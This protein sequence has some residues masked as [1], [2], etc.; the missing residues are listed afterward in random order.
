MLSALS[1]WLFNT[2]GLSPHGFLPALGARTDLALCDFRRGDRAGLL[3]HPLDAHHNR[4]T[5]QRPR[6]SADAMAVRRLHSALRHNPL[7]RF[8]DPVDAALRPAGAR[9]GG[10]GIASIFTT[11][12]LWLSLPYFLSFPSIAQMRRANEALL[13]SEERLAQAQKMEAVGQLAGGSRTTSITCF[14]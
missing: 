1:E 2:S 11:I 3:F 14:R 9:Q 8:G 13:A 6:L 7:A 5:T 4:K 10:D 12:A